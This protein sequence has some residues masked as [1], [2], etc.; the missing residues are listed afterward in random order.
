VD[1]A[2]REFY[3]MTIAAASEKSSFLRTPQ[4]VV[5]GQ[6]H[7]AQRNARNLFEGTEETDGIPML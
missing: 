6:A 3:E 1:N 4:T 2:L 5:R 7:H